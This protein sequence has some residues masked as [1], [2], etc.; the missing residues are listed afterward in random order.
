MAIAMSIPIGPPKL[1]RFER[2]RIIGAR[3]LQIALGA[4]LLVKPPEKMTKPIDIAITELEKGVLPV[5]VRRKLPDG[6]SYDIP[7]QAFFKKK[8][9]E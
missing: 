4:P 2:A 9:K 5:T 8:G 7:L 6:T 1:T 3:A